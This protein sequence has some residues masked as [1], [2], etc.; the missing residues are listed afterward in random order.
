MYEYNFKLIV[1]GNNNVGKSSIVQVFNNNEFSSK[2]NSTIGID[3]SSKVITVD[4]TN[5]KLQIWDTAGSERFNSIVKNYY[6]DCLGVAIVF[7]VSDRTSFDRV[8]ALYK[9]AIRNTDCES[10]ELTIILVGNKC[11][12]IKNRVV[13]YDEAKEMAD[14]LHIRYMEASAK[15]NINIVDIFQYI[16]NTL[17]DKIKNNQIR[18]NDSIKISM[19]TLKLS[20]T[21]SNKSSIFNNDCCAIS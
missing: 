5:I 21:S 8:T 17:F 20:E 10:Q 15:C 7:D 16:G 4:D 14:L 13:T 3:F 19:S 6:R 12:I 2:Y 11:D 1:V 18:L 9:D